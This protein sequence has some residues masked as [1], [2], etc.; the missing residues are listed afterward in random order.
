V[1]VSPN[2]PGIPKDNNDRV[3]LEYERSLQRR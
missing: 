1:F 2:V 3:Y